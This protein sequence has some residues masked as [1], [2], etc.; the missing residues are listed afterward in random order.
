M[1]AEGSDGD[2]PASYP[3]PRTQGS[4][5]TTRRLFRGRGPGGLSGGLPR[6]G[7]HPLP[8][9]G[10]NRVARWFHFCYPAFTGGPFG[11]LRPRGP[12]EKSLWLPGAQTPGSVRG[13]LPYPAFVPGGA[14]GVSAPKVPGGITL[15]TRRSS[16]GPP[17]GSS[18]EVTSTTRSLDAG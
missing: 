7:S 10:E 1:G 16:G 14:P 15:A 13:H 18:P 9:A 17:G 12:E 6:G 8:G 4:A 3:A 11:G 5:P 2:S